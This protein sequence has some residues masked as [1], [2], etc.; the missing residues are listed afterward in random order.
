[1]K[2]I[3]TKELSVSYYVEGSDSQ[4]ALERAE[5]EEYIMK[6]DKVIGLKITPIEGSDTND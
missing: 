3:V 1:M 5:L 4:E 2:Y 6:E